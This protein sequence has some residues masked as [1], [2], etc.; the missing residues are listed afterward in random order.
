VLFGADQQFRLPLAVDAGNQIMV[1]SSKSGEI[2][3]ARFAVHEPDQKRIVSN[4]VDQMIR[5]I[6]ELGGT[7]PDVVQALQEAKAAG[8]LPSRLADDALPEAGR[9]YDRV[10]GKPGKADEQEFTVGSPLPDLLTTPADGSGHSPDGSMRRDEA[11]PHPGNSDQ[12]PRHW[13]TFFDRIMG[14]TPGESTTG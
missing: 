7:Y 13:R 9:R 2:V 4:S 8:A 5:A 11:E 6:V 10:A 12:K 3:V 1:T 14:R